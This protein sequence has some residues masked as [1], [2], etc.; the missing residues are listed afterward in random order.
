MAANLGSNQSF[1]MGFIVLSV[2]YSLVSKRVIDRQCMHAHLCNVV[3]LIAAVV[4]M[5]GSQGLL[6]TRHVAQTMP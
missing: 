1:D 2:L 6:I 3:Q 4:S 5:L